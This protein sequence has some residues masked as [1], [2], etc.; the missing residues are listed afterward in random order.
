MKGSALSD[1]ILPD[2]LLYLFLGAVFLLA[3]LLL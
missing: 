2:K 1:F 3:A